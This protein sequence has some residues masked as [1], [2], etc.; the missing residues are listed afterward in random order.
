MKENEAIRSDITKA[1]TQDIPEVR[2]R[3]LAHF[4]T[5]IKDFVEHMILAYLKWQELESMIND[6]QRKAYV[7]AIVFTT[8]NLHIVSFRLFLSGYPVA[9]GNLER[10]VIE[11]IALAIL[12]SEKSLNVL[13]RYIDNAYT[14]NKA[15]GHLKKHKDKLQVSQDGLEALEKGLKFYHKYSHPSL[16]TIAEQIG[17]QDQALYLGP[18]FDEGKIAEYEKEVKGRVSLARTFSNVIQGVVHRVAKW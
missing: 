6:D 5:E 16:L 15:V 8:I 12:C 11:T 7:A 4:E 14:T 2:E 1:I 10:Q 9:A 13:D 17:F 3:F 18:S